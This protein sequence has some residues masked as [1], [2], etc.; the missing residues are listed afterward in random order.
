MPSST[1]KLGEL[2]RDTENEL[3]NQSD[4]HFKLETDVDPGTRR[5]CRERRFGVTE[6]GRFQASCRL[7]G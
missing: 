6:L 5:G 1:S 7:D 3:D 2:V 4:G